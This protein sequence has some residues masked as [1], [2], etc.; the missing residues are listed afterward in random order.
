MTESNTSTNPYILPTE[1]QTTFRITSLG[2][3]IGNFII[4][5]FIILFILL[6]VVIIKKINPVWLRLIIAFLLSEG[7]LH[8]F[9]ILAMFIS[10]GHIFT[11]FSILQWLTQ[12]ISQ[13]KYRIY[14]PFLVEI[15]PI[16]F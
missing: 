10:L 12:L 3:F 11:S 9:S 6:Q 8:I 4:P 15:P 5:I 13:N 7:I 14:G 2:E 1:N 16:I